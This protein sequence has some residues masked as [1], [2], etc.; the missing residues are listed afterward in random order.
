MR[1]VLLI[2]FAGA[3]VT[4]LVLAAAGFGTGFG[5]RATLKLAGTHPVVVKGSSFKRA[6]GVRLVAVADGDRAVDR[7]RARATG[8]F[9]ATF[10]DF[11]FDPCN[12]GLLVR[13]V[14]TAG[15]TAELKVVQRECPPKL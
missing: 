9:T 5:S 6:E 2:T 15:S 10:E 12:G 3:A 8:T 14:G 4:A 1:R 7:V 13:A 11:E